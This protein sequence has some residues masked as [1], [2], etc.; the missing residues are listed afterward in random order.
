[1]A[2]AAT[3][4]SSGTKK[5]AGGKKKKT[6]AAFDALQSQKA[7]LH[8]E[9]SKSKK[10]K[11]TY[12]G[13]LDRARDIIAEVVEKRRAEVKTGQGLPDGIDTDLLAVALDGKPNKLSA[14][15]LELCI[16]Q[17]CVVEGLSKSTAEGLHGAW[18]NYWDGLPGG[19]YAGAYKYDEET[20]TVT[21]C[22]AR[23]PE[24][25]AL[26][27]SVKNKSRVKGEAATRR[28]AEA[29]TIE[30]IRAMM[31]WSEGLCSAE[32]LEKFNPKNLEE[33]LLFLKHAMMRG[34]LPSGYCLWT[35]NFEL[36]QLQERDLKP[37]AK[38]PA[39]YYLPVLKVHLENRKGWQNKQGYDGPLESNHYD[40]YD[41][42]D[43]PEICMR[44]HFMCWRKIYRQRLGREFEPDDYAFP[45]IAPNG[46][47]HP[48]RPM[49]H[50]LVQE[51]INEFA[52]GAGIDKIFTTHC[53]RRG[54]S[55][56]RFM[57]AAIGKRWSLTIIRWWG[58]WA[59][60]EQVD[61]LM[62]YLMDS[63]QSYESGHGDALNPHRLQMDK[64]FM[65][66]HN[67][68]QAPTIVEFRLLSEQ[69]LTK[70]NNVSLSAS[71]NIHPTSSTTANS[72]TH[73]ATTTTIPN[74]PRPS[75]IPGNSLGGSTPSI[76]PD[77]NQVVVH[78]TATI[79]IP[80]VLIP[81]VGRD[82]SA[83]RHAI[84]QWYFGDNKAGLTPLK[85]WPPNY[86]TGA[87]RL[88]TGTLYSNRKLLAMEY[89]R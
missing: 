46:I 77:Q 9:Y 13:Y 83:W 14:T 76:P 88:V 78:P 2:R 45:Y 43:T 12:S 1:M 74:S 72:P 30:D 87:M 69:I 86:Y 25:Q 3:S 81:S 5:R 73:A 19:K 65:G 29:T 63:L 32:D 27:K 39:P 62:R 18:A 21:G 20:D 66:D 75:L 68:L 4:A 7:A 16:T 38:G 41:Q 61:T 28:H 17:K 82:A 59:E 37:N 22:P 58:G 33:L 71:S 6:I 80:G 89:E 64:S 60:G 10:T 26:L 55:Q 35:R 47:I 23:A 15:A 8:G 40:I 49:S 70:L 67:A 52:R 54:G 53:L 56:Y 44:T 42:K 24:V 51:H 84:D 50:D 57:F 79:P 31:G 11:S 36:C 85:D 48:K 34:F